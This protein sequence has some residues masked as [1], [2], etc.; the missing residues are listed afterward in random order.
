MTS[1]PTH[2]GHDGMAWRMWLGQKLGW[3]LAEIQN[4]LLDTFTKRSIFNGLKVECA[5]VG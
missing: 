2:H 1:N 3:G 5:F 4:L